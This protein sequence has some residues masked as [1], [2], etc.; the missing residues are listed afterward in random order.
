[1]PQETSIIDFQVGL[2]V[3]VRSGYQSWYGKFEKITPTTAL[4]L[5]DD[6][7]RR[8]FSR[9]SR[10]EIGSRETRYKCPYLC[11]VAEAVEKDR[12]Y[13]AATRRAAARI[14]HSAGA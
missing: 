7:S 10:F 4:V 2:R 14:Q 11:T 9:N 3:A 6:G 5:M 1:M 13:A 8:R 12:E